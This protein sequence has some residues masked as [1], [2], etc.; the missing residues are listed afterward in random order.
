MYIVNYAKP[1]GICFNVDCFHSWCKL[2]V[3]K[4]MICASFSSI[5]NCPRI[6]LWRWKWTSYNFAFGKISSLNKDIALNI[7]SMNIHWTQTC[8]IANKV[9]IKWT[10]YFLLE[11]IKALGHLYSEGSLVG[12]NTFYQTV[13]VIHIVGIWNSI[14][15]LYQ[16]LSVYPGLEPYTAHQHAPDYH[17]CNKTVD[18]YLKL[19]ISLG[20]Y[21]K[22]LSEKK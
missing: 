8:F 2:Q 15:L 4:K 13:T 18:N 17:S 21:C 5:M 16:N 9:N 1:T 12:F 6:A 11:V 22:N 14:G 3:M 7:N 19:D 20:R 10:P